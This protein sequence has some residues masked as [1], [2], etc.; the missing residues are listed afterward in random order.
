MFC[1]CTI[2]YSRL[3]KKAVATWDRFNSR[4]P[5]ANVFL[6]QISTA[7]TTKVPEPTGKL[8]YSP[9]VTSTGTVFYVRSGV[10]CGNHVSLRE[11]SSG[12]DTPLAA[13]PSGYDVYKTFAVDEGGGVTSLYFDRYQCSTGKSHIYKLTIS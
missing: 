10:G 4:T 2:R 6:Y 1:T 3:F 5:A 12:I 8:Q 9:S 11:Y 13:L 7:T